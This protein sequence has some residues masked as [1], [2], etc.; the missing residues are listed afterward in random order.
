MNKIN[1]DHGKYDFLYQIP[2]LIYSTLISVTINFILKLLAL[3][4][5]QI[6][7]IRKEKNLLNVQLK[8]NNIIKRLKIKLAFFFILS[9]LFML[10][11]WYF[12]S[13]FCSVYKNTQKILIIDT[14]ISFTLSMIYPFI[15]NLF[16]GFFRIPAL[17][18]RGKDRQYL[19]ALSGYIAL[20]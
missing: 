3:S 11:F 17:R 14:L 15:I 16:P 8:T 18:A 7:D 2:Q 10:F 4:E 19:Y 12:I 1:A 5:N 9:F 6:L 20:I 13:C